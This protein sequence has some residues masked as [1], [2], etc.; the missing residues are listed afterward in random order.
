M[1]WFHHDTDMHQN[2]KIRKLIRVHGAT[3]YAFWCLLLEKLYATEGDFQVKADELW[4]E[5]FAEDLKL[6]D[7]RTPIRILDTLAELKLINSQLWADHI[8][9]VPEVKKEK[10]TLKNRLLAYSEYR[11][12]QEFVFKRDGFK[13]V[14][15]GTDKDLTLDHQI[16]QSRGGGHEPE[17]LVTCCATC[18]SSKGARTPEEWRG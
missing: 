13:C 10:E 15:C 17:N 16:P 7:Y 14:Y 3:G 11:K 9:C 18:N 1:K 4:F 8:I 2:R 5:D 12:H 6:G